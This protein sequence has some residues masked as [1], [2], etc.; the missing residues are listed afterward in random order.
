MA[1]GTFGNLMELRLGLGHQGAH[2][3]RH[4][5]GSKKALRVFQI[6]PADYGTT[7]RSGTTIA[8]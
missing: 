3:R 2:R 1:A 6:A 5:H 7:N 8:E 4:L